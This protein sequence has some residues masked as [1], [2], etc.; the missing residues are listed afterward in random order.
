MKLTTADAMKQQP[1][2]KGGIVVEGQKLQ[3][4]QNCLKSAYNLLYEECS[5]RGIC[6]MLGG[7]SCLGA[8][9]HGGFIPWDDD[10]DLNI[11]RKD[12][13]PLVSLL[14]EELSDYF[15][16]HTPEETDGYLLGFPQARIK[17]TIYRGRD[18]YGTDGEYGVPIDFFVIENTPNNPVLRGIH[19]FVSLVLG[20]AL[21]CRKFAAYSE[22]YLAMSASNPALRQIVNK[23]VRIGRIVSFSSIDSWRKRWDSWNSMCKNSHSRYVT[24]PLG[25]RHYFGE[26][27]ERSVFNP[28]AHAHFCGIDALIAGDFDSYLRGLYGDSYMTVPDEGE[29]ESHIVFDFGIGD[30]CVFGCNDNE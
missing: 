23:K 24:I 28:P 12:Y 20:Y 26:L 10:L 13:E 27:Q 8:V 1:R 30:E 19:G 25:R 7:G 22:E 6:L 5:N 16:L 15:W 3:A 2:Q 9:R 29:R 4:L 17:R 14:K 21:S 11:F 18:D